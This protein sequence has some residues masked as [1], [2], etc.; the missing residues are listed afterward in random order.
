MY[1]MLLLI[2]KDKSGITITEIFEDDYV[3]N[4]EYNLLRKKEE[5]LKVELYRCSLLSVYPNDEYLK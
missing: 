2:Y 3:A 1:K 5:C 4:I